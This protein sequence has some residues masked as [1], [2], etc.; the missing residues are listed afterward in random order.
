MADGLVLDPGAGGGTVMTDDVGG[1]HYPV[2]KIVLGTADQNQGYVATSNPMPILGTAVVSSLPAVSGTVNISGTVPTTVQSG[3]ITRIQGVTPGV[4][5]TDLGK[6]EDAAHA[7]GDTGVLLLGVRNDQS[8]SPAATTSND[9]DYAAL[10]VDQYGSLRIT[11]GV[12]VSGI[13]TGNSDI[14]K[15]EDTAHQTG[16]A[17]ML[18]LG[19]RR[20][21]EA[22]GSDTDG[23]YS[24]LNVDG[25][26][27]LRTLATV[28]GTV[29]I[30]VENAGTLAAITGTVPVRT[31]NNGTVS[32][33]NTVNTLENSGTLAAISGTVNIHA[34]GGTVTVGAIAAGDNNIGNVDVASIAAGDNNIGNVDIVTMPAVSGT[35]VITP[36]GTQ[37]VHVTGGTLA[38]LQGTVSTKEQSGTVMAGNTDIYNVAGA[39]LTIR[40]FGTQI[41]AAAAATTDIIAGTTGIKLRLLSLNLV[42]DPANGTVRAFFSDGNLNTG[43]GGLSGTTAWAPGAGIALAFNPI[44]HFETTA[45]SAFRLVQAA[46]GTIGIHGVY[47]E[48]P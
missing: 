38:A 2:S 11:G 18:M 45:G 22:V 19:V 21:A 35:V 43:I 32:V 29:P 9:G 3:T 40:R 15:A 12:T 25:S 31:T 14:S 1:T 47:A 28:S 7:S 20:N 44:G 46:A 5:A 42:N 41:A 30:T 13:G 37:N 33:S 24:T 16:D 4:A 17:G 6:A 27:R 26:G 34:T 48:V 23:D 8:P 39:N 10:Q 36:S